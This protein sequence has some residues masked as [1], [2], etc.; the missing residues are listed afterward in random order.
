MFYMLQ[1]FKVH[2]CRQQN[3]NGPWSH[4]TYG[5][6]DSLLQR[7]KQCNISRFCPPS[8]QQKPEKSLNSRVQSGHCELIQSCAVLQRTIFHPLLLIK[9]PSHTGGFKVIKFVW[10]SFQNSSI[11]SLFSDL[12]Q[13][14]NNNLHGPL[15]ACFPLLEKSCFI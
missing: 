8:F 9:P 14:A 12:R 5:F 3:L 4:F 1:N 10:P 13:A 7:R 15:S 6:T 11:H 2:H